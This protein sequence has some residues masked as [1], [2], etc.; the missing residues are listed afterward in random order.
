MKTKTKSLIIALAAAMALGAC[1]NPEV[2]AG[3]EG[4]VFYQPLIFGKMEYRKSLTGPSST[5]V[6]WRLFIVNIDMRER[7]YREEF[8]LLSSDDLKVKFEV[9]TRVRLREGSVREIV[10]DWGGETWYEWNV[11]QPLRTTVRNEIMKISATEIQL[12][13]AELAKTIK[14]G[15]DAKYKDTPIEVLSVDMGAFEFPKPVT[16]AIQEK[17]GKQQELERQKAILSKTEKEAE[18]RVIEALRAAEQQRIIGS[19]LD[20]LYLQREAVQ[21]YRALGQSKNKTV[22]VLPNTTDGTGMPL[23][24]ST[25]SRKKLSKDD[26]E[27]LDTMRAKYITDKDAS[28]AAEAPDPVDDDADEPAPAE[29]AVT[30]PAPANP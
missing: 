14:A 6:S 8:N 9:N 17:I 22:L 12:K 3:H 2:P 21:V 18:I 23:V 4:Y 20:P 27:F 30:P 25:G 28:A 26:K 7:N 1:T 5:G 24:K 10:E 16:E 29:P 11:R 15:L 13:T 19:T